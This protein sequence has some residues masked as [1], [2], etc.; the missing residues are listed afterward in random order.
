MNK[1]WT[2]L[3]ALA[4][5]SLSGGSFA[6]AQSTQDCGTTLTGRD[7]R[8]DV[9]VRAGESCTINNTAVRGNVRVGQHATLI[10]KNSNVQ[11]NVTTDTDF[12]R[13]SLAGA[14]V[15][16]SLNASQGGSL[17]MDDSQITGTVTVRGNKG[18]IRLTRATIN[19]DLT[20][21]GNRPAPTGTWL[22]VDGKQLGQCRGL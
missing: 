18:V 1:L 2:P 12:A 20:C 4:L 7:I 22:R 17:R 8:G 6:G 3:F 13:V 5:C 10:L 21:D 16:G 11:G 19:G 14:I 9:T 15:Q